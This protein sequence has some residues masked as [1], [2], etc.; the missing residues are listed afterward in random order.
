MKG[1]VVS[2]RFHPCSNTTY[3]SGHLLEATDKLH[4]RPV[5]LESFAGILGE[6]TE[7]DKRSEL[8]VDVAIL[9]LLAD[10]A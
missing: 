9:E 10:S 5:D 2:G 4:I 8:S 6:S 1:I 3:V 7:D